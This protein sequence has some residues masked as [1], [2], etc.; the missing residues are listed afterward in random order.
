MGSVFSSVLLTLINTL[1][2]TETLIFFTPD[3]NECENNNGGCDQTCF[4]SIGSYQCDCFEGYIYSNS[5]NKCNG[6]NTR[7][8][9]LIF[10]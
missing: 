7:L 5:T 1:V 8:S 6:K 2:A 3:I 10:V 4:N 9:A